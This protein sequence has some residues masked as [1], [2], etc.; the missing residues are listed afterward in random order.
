MK[1]GVDNR[2]S[3]LCLGILL[4]MA[5]FSCQ[6]AI[7]TSDDV[8]PNI[9]LIVSE[10]HGQ[11]IGAYGNEIVT[12][13]NIDLLAEN[14]VMFL[15]AYT[16]YSVCSPSRSSILTGLYPH[17]NG[18]IGL[19]THDFEMYKSFENI[20]SYLKNQGYKTGCLGKLHV[21]PEASFP[22]DF[23]EI[24][25]SNFAKKKMGDYAIKAAEFINSSGG[26]PFFLMVNF[27]DAHFP[28]LRKVDGL[29]TIEVNENQISGTL[30][31]VGV[32]S[33]R[34]R[35]QTADYYSQI[36]RLDESIGMLMDS[37]KSSGKAENTL[38]IFLSDHGAQFSRGKTTSY[39]AGLKIPL[40]MNWPKGLKSKKLK[41]EELVS[42]VDLFP[43]IVDAVSSQEKAE[44]PGKSLIKIARDQLPGHDYIYAGGMIGTA[45]YFYPKRSVR[46]KQ[47]KLIHNL[48]S[49]E[50]DPYFTVYTDHV[51]ATVLSG[52]SRAEIASST[53]EI[54]AVYERWESPPAYEFYDLE[55]DPWEFNNLADIPDYQEEMERLKLVLTNWRVNTRD[56]FID[57][58]MFKRIKAEVDSINTLYPNHS[59]QKDTAFHWSYPEYFGD[60]VLNA[61]QN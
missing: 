13:P 35:A 11:D 32:D 59:Y 18:Q 53:D 2:I 33:E 15:N 60:Y 54:K 1:K 61:E 40:I 6:P 19:A 22:F 57:P 16:T 17:Q 26:K 52:S 47:Y 25:S 12:T 50:R 41:S 10:D 49:G 38:V 56:P 55:T 23:H 30:P 39:E 5:G 8:K 34:L 45:K 7:K 42:V 20:P 36:N 14:G 58:I 3:I 9:L 46:D 27:P 44:L 28:L 51:Y 43:T 37:L 31:F 21:N 48:Y 4:L 29:P 24:E